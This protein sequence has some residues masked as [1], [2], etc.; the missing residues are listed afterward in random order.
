MMNR[1]Q[2]SGTQIHPKI[3]EKYEYHDLVGDVFCG[4]CE[5]I[6]TRKIELEIG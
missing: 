2:L 4:M 1:S 6:S 3:I 5:Y